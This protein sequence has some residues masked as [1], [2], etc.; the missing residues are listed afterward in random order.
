M[1]N[2]HSLSFRVQTDVVVRFRGH[3]VPSYGRDARKGSP[4]V[5]AWSVTR[6]KTRIQKTQWQIS[7]KAS[8]W[9]YYAIAY[10]SEKICNLKYIIH[11]MD[12]S[13]SL[14]QFNIFLQPDSKNKYWQCLAS[15]ANRLFSFK[16]ACWF[17]FYIFFSFFFS[18]RVLTKCS[19][20]QLVNVFVL[21]LTR[22]QVQ[23]PGVERSL[24]TLRFSW[25]YGF[26]VICYA[27]PFT[28]SSSKSTKTEPSNNT[29]RAQN[30]IVS[31]AASRFHTVTCL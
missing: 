18:L 10:A 26:S 4:E 17:F 7:H 21:V 1:A 11:N 31:K 3:G 5:D 28:S 2:S 25:V 9:D 16:Y 20:A 30:P 14:L 6:M 24:D 29:Q 15:G 12:G 13:L 19:L 8:Q 22:E 23:R 27:R